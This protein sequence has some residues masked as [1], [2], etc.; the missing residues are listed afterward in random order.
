MSSGT[1][2][3]GL[4]P[5][6]SQAGHQGAQQAPDTKQSRKEHRLICHVPCFKTPKL[7]DF[8]MT[9]VPRLPRVGSHRTT[10]AWWQPWACDKAVRADEPQELSAPGCA[11]HP[12]GSPPPSAAACSLHPRLLL[13]PS[14]QLASGAVLF[15]PPQATTCFWPPAFSPH[16]ILPCT[17]IL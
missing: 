10:A 13:G 7:C 15:R 14:L 12:A 5:S 4:S 11:L 6:Q 9:R 17:R 3:L 16:L 2:G 1:L 8:V